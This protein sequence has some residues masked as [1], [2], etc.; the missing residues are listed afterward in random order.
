LNEVAKLKP[1]FAIV[2]A[3]GKIILKNI[4][5]L[6]PF[7]NIHPSFLPKY[8]GPSP[9]QYAL[10]NDDKKTGVSIMFLDPGMDTGPIVWQREVNINSEEN[11]LTLGN[12]LFKLAAEKL[13]ELIKNPIIQLKA[14]P[15]NDKN[16]TY[17]KLICRQ[18]G[19][20]KKGENLSA[21]LRA[22]TIWPGVFVNFQ[23]KRLK[24]IN[25]DIVQLEGKRPTLIKDFI[26]GH[27]KAKESLNELS[28]LH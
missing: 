15:Q 9:L 6:C 10:L 4:L 1:K 12:R 2:V 18:D 20:F 3:Y 21:K 7:I 23:G 24:I 27:P 13:A 11:W 14:M 16:A 25:K 22:L 26:N 8:R 5:K 28:L 19:L 17:T